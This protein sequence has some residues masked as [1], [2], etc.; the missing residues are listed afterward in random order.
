V[1]T[2]DAWLDCPVPVKHVEVAE[3]NRV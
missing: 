3:I 1:M 2:V